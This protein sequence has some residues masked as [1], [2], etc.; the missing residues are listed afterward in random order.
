M[1][2]ELATVVEFL[3]E[4]VIY[5]E[6]DG[7]IKIWNQAAERIFGLSREQAAKLTSTNH[8]WGLV[9]EDGSPCPGLQHP[10][11]ITL[12]TGQALSNQV[13]GLRRPGGQVTWLSI[14][15]RPV[16]SPGQ[17]LPQA[18]VVSFAEVTERKAAEEALRHSEDKFLTIFNANPLALCITT[19]E[20]VLLEVNHAY[21]RRTGYRREELLGRTGSELD[22]WVEPD[23]RQRIM[24][25]LEHMENGGSVEA[26]AR[27]KSGQEY[28]LL[29]SAQPMEL[30]GQACLLWA[31]LD[32]SERKQAEQ[33]LRESEARYRHL[34]EVESDA[35]FLVDRQ[36]MRILEANSAAGQLYGYSRD[37]LLDMR[38]FDLSTE[39]E[40]T[41]QTIEQ[42]RTQVSRRLHRR[43]DGGVFPVEVAAS[44]MTLGG[45]DLHIGAVRDI[46]E[47]EKAMEAIRESEERF[48]GLLYDIPTVAVQGY[49]VDGVTQYWNPASARL[50]GYSE[51]EALGRNLLELII[52]PEMRED[53]R[54]AV[55]QMAASGQPIPPSELSL[56]RKDGSRVEVFSSHAVVRRPGGETEL[57]CLDVD[58]SQLKRAEQER[59]ELEDRLRQ[60]Q[61]MEALGTLAGG[62]AH[63]FNNLLASIMGF[64]E[65]AGDAVAPDGQAASDIQQILAAAHKGKLLVRQVMAFSQAQTPLKRPL[66]LNQEII[67]V[68]EGMV[69]ALPREV[70]V[71]TRLAAR[72]N[73]VDADAN[74][75][76]QALVNLINNAAQAMPQ[77]GQLTIATENADLKENRC[78]GCG[79]LLPG[80]MVRLTVSDTGRGLDKPTLS[81]VFEPFFS[82]RGVGKGAGLGLSTV[83]GVVQGHGGH[84]CGHSQPGGGASFEVYLPA[85]EAPAVAPQARDQ[86]VVLPGGPQ[87]ILVVDDEDALRELGRRMLA[88]K[89]YEVTCAASGEEALELYRQDPRRF[90]CVVLDLGMPGMGGQQALEEIKALDPQAKVIVASGHT[91]GKQGGQALEAGAA[92]FVAKP[93]RQA[94]LLST[95]RRVLEAG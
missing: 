3:E 66:N 76:G 62:V 11:M 28:T 26:R 21:Q 38:I 20:G 50:Y 30:N 58:I 41:R 61:K 8:E 95:L 14:N 68:L 35:L 24:A 55:A 47:R 73:L 46:S 36:S 7:Q 56:M 6:A 67:H 89:G 69:A 27:A 22:F 39:P 93:F 60:A 80:G 91:A 94:E 79:A 92:A 72:L 54:L 82:T 45:R 51:Q 15:T 70:N 52:P 18:V 5:Q 19:P 78:A 44:Y 42:G 88:A 32:I 1:E 74:H 33:A 23:M 77:G 87:R 34:F 4:G 9:Y 25:Y 57:F 16:F 10:S 31:A 84:V 29:L 85:L 37:E 40:K 2:Q 71:R 63:E 48:R 75:L 49:S 81:R 43:K 83:Y 65:L 90:A 64:A 53:V 86:P 59:A 17:A 13:R 12:A